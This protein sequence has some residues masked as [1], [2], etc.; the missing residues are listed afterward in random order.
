MQPPHQVQ[1]TI[2]VI[3]LWHPFLVWGTYWGEPTDVGVPVLS[4]GFLPATVLR[5]WVPV[6][7]DKNRVYASNISKFGGRDGMSG[8]NKWSTIKHKKGRVDSLRSRLWT[9]LVKEI[10]V[11]ARMGGGDPNG[12]ARLRLAVDNAR[13]NNMPNDNIERA[14]K[15]GTGELE[16]VNYEDVT[17]EG[18]GPEGVA[19][20][21]DTTTDNRNRTVGEIRN[22]FNKNNGKMAE[23]GSVAWMFGSKGY[24]SVHAEG[25]SEDDLLMTILDAGADDLQRSG[26]MFEIYTEMSA[27]EAVRKAIAAAGFNIAEAKLVKVPQTMTKVTGKSA[28]QTMKLL[29]LLE[30]NDDVSMVWSNADI[31]ENEMDTVE[32]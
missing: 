10:T 21:V 23:S 29:D 12:N 30:E 31:D 3:V 14:I 2:C 6:A 32:S 26:D 1:G 25:T 18:Y 24:V 27:F 4:K 13:S 28:E 5:H 17:Y 16:G 19:I 22:L 11:A 7:F 20:L 9:K 15:K 8:H